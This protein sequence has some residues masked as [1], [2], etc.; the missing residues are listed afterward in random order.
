MWQQRRLLKPFNISWPLS[1]TLSNFATLESSLEHDLQPHT[2]TE[3]RSSPSEP[4]VNELCARNPIEL[5]HDRVKC[6]D[7][8]HHKTVTLSDGFFVSRNL[9]LG[10]SSLQSFCSGVNVT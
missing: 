1:K 10:A 3:D 7:T 4:L 5:L 9:D 6:P 8:W 2:N